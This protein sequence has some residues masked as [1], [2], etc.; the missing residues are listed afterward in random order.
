MGL[1]GARSGGRSSTPPPAHPRA[2]PPRLVNPFQRARRAS[3][4]RGP[5]DDP[6]NAQQQQHQHVNPGVLHRF[7]FRGS[8]SRGR[9][10]GRKGSVRGASLLERDEIWQLEYLP[11]EEILYTANFA[12]E[13]FA[14]MPLPAADE[15]Y[16]SGKKSYAL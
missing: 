15:V 5:S 14:F 16:F 1:F 3:R 4:S 8:L 7:A 6:Q 11:W 12:R 9:T 13:E 10:G 2:E